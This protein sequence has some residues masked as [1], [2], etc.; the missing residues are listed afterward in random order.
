MD[1]ETILDYVT[2]TPENTNRNVLRGMLDNFS[3]S[4]GSSDL[5]AVTSEDNGKV[6]TVIDGRWDKEISNGVVVFEGIVTDS[7][8]MVVTVSMSYNDVINANFSILKVIEAGS[9][10]S[11]INYFSL[12]DTHFN[13]NE[14]PAYTVSYGDFTFGA[15]SPNVPLTQDALK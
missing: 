2:E 12:R 11:T 1:K 6:L 8:S 9:N 7:E 13:S 5:P 10:Y 3:K 14:N 4:G 15:N